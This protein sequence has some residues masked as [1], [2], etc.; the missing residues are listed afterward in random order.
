M[1]RLGT[2]AGEASAGAGR[3]VTALLKAYDSNQVM[4]SAPG[5]TSTIIAYGMQEAYRTCQSNALVS[6]NYAVQCRDDGT[7]KLVANNINCTKCIEGIAQWRADRAA[8][9]AEARAT[10]AD[11][12][13]EDLDPAWTAVFDDPRTGICRY[14]CFQCVAEDVSQIFNINVS[15]TCSVYN[16]RFITA[17]VHGVQEQAQREVAANAQ[18]L[19]TQGLKIRDKTDVRNVSVAITNSIQQVVTVETLA[20][21]H[22]AVMGVQSTTIG[23]ADSTSIVVQHLRQT[24]T[25]TM[26]ASMVQTQIDHTTFRANIQYDANAKFLS[27]DV[28]LDATREQLLQTVNTF[29]VL[30]NEALGQLIV[31]LVCLILAGIFV[32]LGYFFFRNETHSALELVRAAPVSPRPSSVVI[33]KNM[34]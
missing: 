14:M 5:V 26:L 34:A 16:E 29:Q 22:S 13:T 30:V 27:N 28:S 15:A 10:N 17:F 33:D 20:D 1:V 3:E 4:G 12:V 9:D 7:G 6:Q 8:L 11:Y 31:I 32:G 18:A 21:L 23:S 19:N 25:L 24:I 2:L